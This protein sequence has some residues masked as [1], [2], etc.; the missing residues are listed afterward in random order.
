MHRWRWWVLV[1]LLLATGALISGARFLTFTTNYRVFFNPDNPYLQALD[2][3]HDTYTKDDTVLFVLTPKEGSVFNL[4]VLDDVEW[5]TQQA[6]LIPYVQRVDSLQNFQYTVG[7][8]NELIVRDLYRDA[9]T[10]TQGDMAAIRRIAL[11]EPLLVQRVVSPDG[12]VT[13]V[14]VT[15]RLPEVDE[16]TEI[17]KVVAHVR[18]LARQL[19]ERDPLLEV[20]LTGGVMMSQAFPEAS[21]QDMGTLFP[22]MFGL[23]FVAMWL[24]L[25]SLVAALWAYL[26]LLL[27]IGATM[28]LAGWLGFRIS[29]PSAAAPNIILTLAVADCVHV[30][31]TF[32]IVLRRG[33]LSPLDWRQFQFNAM[34][35]SLKTNLQPVFLTSFTTALGF[36]SLNFSD[37]PPFRD[38]GN[39]SAMGVGFAFIYTL[40]LLPLLAMFMPIGISS[41]VSHDAIWMGKL[42]NFVVNRRQALLVIMPA[43]VLCLSGFALRNELNDDLIKYFSPS[44]TFRA[45]TEYATSRL[46]GMYIMEYSLRAPQG[47]SITEPE[48][49]KSLNRFAHWFRNQPETLH[50]YSIADIIKRLNRNMH[51]NDPAWYRIP[52]SRELAA[53]YLLLYQMSLPAGLELNDR[54][55]VDKSASRITITLK[56]L[57]SNQLLDLEQRSDRWLQQNTPDYM[58]AQAAGTVMFAHIGQSN[59]RGMLLGVG[60]AFA[61][62]S[63]TLVVAFRSA[64][65]GL[66]SLIPNVVPALMAFGLW[67]IIHGQI[68][69]G[70]SVVASMTLGIVV[71]DT[72][73][74]L[75]KYLRGRNY[76]QYSPVAAINYAFEQVGRAIWVTSLVLAAGFLVLTLSDF[77]INAQMGLLVAVTIS[78]A[79]MADFLLLPPLLLASE[80]EKKYANATQI[81][82]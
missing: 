53:Q 35:E 8:S 71:D 51:A 69:M 57:S 18:Q 30:L 13:G 64:F 66:V 81:D 16:Q 56:N 68:S 23:V 40:L 28:G 77:E 63:L 25:R 58:Q 65:W 48:Y 7:R 4:R 15:V 49:L 29:P 80:R 33:W 38:L 10:L 21:Q 76:L 45:D 20:R 46:T 55:N 11:S 12:R 50:V 70:L 22:L 52:N 75:S 79:L 73:H 61:V 82:N 1:T 72:V 78:F 37:S 47:G 19:E 67:G 26:A 43:I 24:L 54:I 60:V 5:L 59:I 32:L 42:A 44:V 14:H 34:T 17:P 31:M 74:F 27:S 6:W 3:I 2:T 9:E 36:L 41:A 62:I 39:I